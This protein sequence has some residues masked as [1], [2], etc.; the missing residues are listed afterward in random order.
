M[1]K[2]TFDGPNKLIIV[3]NGITSIDV[4]IDIYSDWKEWIVLSDNAKYPQVISVIGGDEISPSIYLGA[5]FF[6]ENGWK[7]RPYEGNHTLTV[8]GNLYTRDG[9]SPFVST[10][11]SYNVLIK[12]TTSN[13]INTVATDGSGGSSY[14]PEE[15]ANAV[16]S[17]PKSELSASNTAGNVLVNTEANTDDIQALIFA[18]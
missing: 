10:T 7:I 16:W 3:N 2:V 14:T 1:A 17:K 9:S 12:M 5:T 8:S 11:G 15:I 13:L 4:K 18:A 6:L